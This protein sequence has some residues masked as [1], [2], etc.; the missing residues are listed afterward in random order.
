M[1]LFID[2]CN[3]NYRVNTN[4]ILWRYGLR[5]FF[6]YII[7]I[8]MLNASNIYTHLSNTSVFTIPRCGILREER[9]CEERVLPGG[10][11]ITRRASYIT[12]ITTQ[13]YFYVMQ[14]KRFRWNEGKSSRAYSRTISRETSFSHG[15][16]IHSTLCVALDM[17]TIV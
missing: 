2:K 7:F 16:I 17:T 15:N 8:L 1:T 10:T 11:N 6:F 5:Y 12:E 4:L 14:N 3:I 9:R 13:R